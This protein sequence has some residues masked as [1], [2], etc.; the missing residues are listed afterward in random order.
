MMVKCPMCSVA[1]KTETLEHHL[2]LELGYFSW[3]CA[4]CQVSLRSPLHVS[5]PVL[6]ALQQNSRLKKLSLVDRLAFEEPKTKEGRKLL[7]RLEQ[8]DKTLVSV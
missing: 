6:I 8:T 5:T 3:Q 1:V 7:E 2:R 4:L